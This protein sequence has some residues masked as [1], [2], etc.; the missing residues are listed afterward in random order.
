MITHDQLCFALKTDYPTLTPGIDYLTAQK[1][2]ENRVQ[3][4]EAYIFEWKAQGVS[5]PDHAAIIARATVLLPQYAQSL[6]PPPKTQFSVR[7]FRKR[8][9]AAEQ[10]AIRQMSLTDMQVGLVYDDFNSA[11]YIDVTDPDTAAGIDL[12]I[13]KGLLAPDRKAELLTPQAA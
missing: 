5:E 11:E 13:A 4:E 1:L 10:I 6:L 3:I 9:T 12:Y 2:D 7:E 8:F